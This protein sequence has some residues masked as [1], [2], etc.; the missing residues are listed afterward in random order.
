VRY[1]L[2]THKLLW[3]LSD[4]PRLGANAKRILDDPN[5]LLIVSVLVLAE[6][7]HAAD[8]KRVPISFESILKAATASPR[9]FVFPIDIY[10][11][12]YLSSQLDIHDSIIVATSL[13][14]KSY[15]GE[16]MALLTKDIAIT[17]SGLIPV[18]W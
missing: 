18:I 14:C 2:D 6:A 10:T 4:D 1:V 13:H 12:E 11:V 7:K 17:Q 16:D 8:R 5:E 9:V 15:F 3:H